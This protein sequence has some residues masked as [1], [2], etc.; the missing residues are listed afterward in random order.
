ML[1]KFNIDPE[2]LNEETSDKDAEK[3]LKDKFSD[4]K[5]KDILNKESLNKINKQIELEQKQLQ[6]DENMATMGH[7]LHLWQIHNYLLHHQIL[8]LCNLT[9][10]KFYF[11][12]KQ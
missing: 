5:N 9:I 4:P 10:I 8:D 3:I 6:R 11:K 1:Q 12:N 7:F 2:V